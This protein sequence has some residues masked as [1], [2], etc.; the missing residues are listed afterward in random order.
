M[1]K[2]NTEKLESITKAAKITEEIFEKTI[3]NF[4]KFSTEK[5][6]YNFILSEI[7]ARKL[8]PSFKPI[9]GSGPGGSEPHHKPSLP[10]TKGFCVID[11]GVKVNGY[12]ADLT[13]TIYLG[14]PSQ[15]DYKF[16]NLVL[17]SQNQAIKEVKANQKALVPYLTAKKELGEYAENFIH[18][19]GHGLGKHIHIKPFMKKETKDTLKEGD[20]VTVEP[21]IY[22]KG[23][24]GIRIE[25][26]FLITGSECI[27]L[28]VSSR[29]LVKVSFKG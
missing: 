21:G 29:E 9:I 28:T 12:C 22:F 27:P 18:G 1:N 7:N 10:I 13:R 19:L 6:A 16:Y 5:D 23:K 14:E 17:N 24:F 15:E 20:I 3:K 11:L 26:D 4:S 25:D 2:N 8:K